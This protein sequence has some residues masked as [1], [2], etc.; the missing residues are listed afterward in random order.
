MGVDL[1]LLPVAYESGDGR[2]GYAHDVLN[3]GR[4]HDLWDAIRTLPTTPVPA[5]FHTYLSRDDRYE[6]LHYGQTQDDPYG[7]PL[8]CVTAGELVAIGQQERTGLPCNVAVW[9]YLAALPPE[10]RVALYWS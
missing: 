3:C 7:K 6:D 1:T 8:R 4:D 2:W 9:A 5:D 10:T